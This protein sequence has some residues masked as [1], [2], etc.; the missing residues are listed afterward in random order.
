MNLEP[1][2]APWCKP[3]RHPPTSYGLLVDNEVRGNTIVNALVFVASVK[4]AGDRG[5]EIMRVGGVIVKNTI[6]PIAYV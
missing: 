3:L 1:T 6:T 2:P 5:R 4:K